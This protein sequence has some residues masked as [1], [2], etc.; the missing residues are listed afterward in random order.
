NSHWLL[1][2]KKGTQYEVV[3]SLGKHDQLVQLTTTPQARKKWPMLPENIEARLLTKTIKGKS[4]SILTSLTDPLR[5]P[6]A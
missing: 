4:V 1:P 5:Y 2:L 3:R 6:G